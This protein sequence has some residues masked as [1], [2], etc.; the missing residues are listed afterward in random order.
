VGRG[1]LETGGCGEHPG[2]LSGNV[3]SLEDGRTNATNLPLYHWR[4]DIRNATRY[5]ANMLLFCWTPCV[6]KK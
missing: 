6:K 5:K 3:L 4:A 2:K 1:V